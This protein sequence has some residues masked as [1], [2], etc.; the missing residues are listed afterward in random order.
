MYCL[1]NSVSECDGCGDCG[2]KNGCVECGATDF[3]DYYCGEPYCIICAKGEVEK[4][5][6]K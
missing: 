1:K 6:S 5:R 2:Q 4:R 3:I